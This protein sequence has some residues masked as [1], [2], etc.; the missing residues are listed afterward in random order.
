MYFVALSPNHAGA[1]CSCP[2]GQ[3]RPMDDARSGCSHAQAVIA[4]LEAER[5]RTT[6]A[7]SDEQQ[8]AR[9]HRPIINLGDGVVVTSRKNGT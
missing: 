4:H 5:E 3:Y 2:W 6:A 1:T 7:W 8:A 9:Q